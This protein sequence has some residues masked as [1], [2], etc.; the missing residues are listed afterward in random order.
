MSGSVKKRYR[1]GLGQKWSKKWSKPVAKANPY[2]SLIL[3]RLSLYAYALIHVAYTS[4]AKFLKSVKNTYLA[5]H[6]VA[7]ELLLIQQFRLLH[8]QQL[9]EFCKTSKN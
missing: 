7:K 1:P 2:T 3:I 8:S 9:Q 5:A 6:S 4:V